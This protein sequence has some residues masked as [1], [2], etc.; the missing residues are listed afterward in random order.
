MRKFGAY[1][2]LS[3]ELAGDRQLRRTAAKNLGLAKTSIVLKQAHKADFKY[4]PKPGFLYV[5]SRAISSRCNDNFDEFPAIEIKKA[6]RSFLGKPVFVNH[7]NSNHRT[8]RG[9]IVDA[10]LHED[11]NPNGSPDTW[12]EVL[13]EVDAVS[14]PKLAQAILAGHIDKTSMGC[15]VAFSVCSACGNKASSPSEYCFPSGELVNMANGTFK[16]I[17]KVVKGDRVLTHNGPAI[18]TATMQRPYNGPLSI[19]HRIGYAAPLRV[20]YGHEILTNKTLTNPQISGDKRYLD[21]YDSNQ[22]DWVNSENIEKGQWVQ[23]AYPTDEID[24]TIDILGLAPDFVEIGN[25]II[26]ANLTTSGSKRK[27]SNEQVA[28]IRTT[29][30]SGADCAR[31]FGVSQSLISEIRSGKAYTGD[32]VPRIA[33]VRS[34]LPRFIEMSNELAT[35]LGW[36]IAEGSVEG[37]TKLGTPKI[38][39]WSLNAKETHVVDELDRCL[40]KLGIQKCKRYLKHGNG[41]VAKVSNAPLAVLLCK[42]GGKTTSRTKAQK[43]LSPE[44]MLMPIEFQR[45]MLDAYG[46]GDGWYNTYGATECRTSSALLARQ[47]TL[48]GARVYNHIPSWWTNLNNSGGPTNRE[49]LNTIH[50]VTINGQERLQGRRKLHIGYIANRVAKVKTELFNGTVYNIEV[51][52]PNSYVVEGFVVH[53]CQHIPRMK[54]HKYRRYNASTGR[55]QEE[56]IRE[57]CLTPDTPILMADGTEIP[58]S[59]IKIGDI[60]LDHLGESRRVTEIMSREI[61]ES[62]IKIEK[63]G[64]WKPTQLTENHPVLILP[65]RLTSG[66]VRKHMV[67][68]LSTGKIAPEFIPASEIQVGDFV[69]EVIPNPLTTLLKIDIADWSILDPDNHRE[70]PPETIPDKFYTPARSWKSRVHT[71]RACR[72]CGQ[73]MDLY[74]SDKDRLYCSSKCWG[75]GC[76]RGNSSHSG[77]IAI[78]LPETI[79]MN[80][81]FGRWCGWFLAEGSISYQ[82]N[83]RHVRSVI[84]ALHVSEVNHANEIAHLGE[85]LFGVKGHHTVID[86]GRT[87]EFFNANLARFMR[88]LGDN[89]YVKY[90]PDEWMSAP[91]EFL[92]AVVTAHHDGDGEHNGGKTGGISDSGV[93]THATSSPRL[94][95]QLYVLHLMLG[96]TPTRKHPDPPGGKSK[97]TVP[98]H[99]IRARLDKDAQTRMMWGPWVFVPVRFIEQEKYCGTVYNI[100]VEGTHT[101]VANHMAVHNCHGL[102]FFENSLLVEDPADP[103]AL[104]LGVDYLGKESGNSTPG[105]QSTAGKYTYDI[106][107]AHNKDTL[108]KGE[109]VGGYS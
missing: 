35:I 81:E 88:V 52:G 12:C 91:I 30:N 64:N 90:L 20:T 49:K 43:V 83:R 19:I 71:L 47:L 55:P 108:M 31:K 62:L 86:N 85:T 34:G 17:E 92:D 77:T 73:E 14:Y 23:S 74:P 3:A 58:I 16:S 7:A 84:F 61:D 72:S 41:M 42:L 15:D 103:T 97:R 18:V 76:A 50:H 51:D 69:A 22:W 44:V 46:E 99:H 67:H 87:V 93:M 89:C 21:I 105:L 57:I 26:L 104:T 68:R 2:V 75:D 28:F 60:V 54:G 6:F 1:Q 37:F 95:D 107:F 4:D 65:R 59:L 96:H 70:H 80:R 106:D 109:V 79:E 98:G 94:A 53:N 36:Y 48:I 101:Y 40:E 78:S 29:K 9:V 11:T 63:V 33:W 10:A 56:I 38:I 66:G 13:M 45:K 8:A 39:A 5:R 100:G 82:K 102:A 27:L 32:P 25:Q 24:F